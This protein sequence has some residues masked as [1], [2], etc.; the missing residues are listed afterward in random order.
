MISITYSTIH[1]RPRE[2]AGLSA[3]IQANL[4]TQHSRTSKII[5]NDRTVYTVQ[6]LCE[7]SYIYLYF[8]LYIF[9]VRGVR[10]FRVCM[11]FG[12]SIN[13]MRYFV[14]WHMEAGLSMSLLLPAEACD[15]PFR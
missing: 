9:A 7:Y 4:M 14:D 10:K 2:E 12:M 15:R 11:D 1:Q 3:T 6:A 13:G 8:P 5:T